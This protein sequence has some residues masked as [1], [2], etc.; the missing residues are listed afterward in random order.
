[1]STAM[2]SSSSTNL[3]VRAPFSGSQQLRRTANT[4]RPRF[5]VTPMAVGG[6]KPGSR[7]EE[8]RERGTDDNPAEQAAKDFE[9]NVVDPFVKKTQENSGLDAN[10]FNQTAD[11]ASKDEVGAFADTMSFAGLA[12]EIINGRGAMVGMLAA[13]GA[14]I[15]THQPILKQIQTAPVLVLGAFGTI[16]LAS[17]I[18][19]VRGADLAKKGAGP[20]TPRA[21]V[22]NGRLAMVSFAT[23]ILVET[24][25]AGPG[26]V[27]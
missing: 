17:I 25:K 8:T 2:L 26:L 15:N 27:P 7:A 24:F 12:P 14:E 23:L 6:G 13:L 5:A 11:S 22:W 1:M 20:F 10:A 21:E 4:A 3:R 18:P 19:I 16:I 9:R